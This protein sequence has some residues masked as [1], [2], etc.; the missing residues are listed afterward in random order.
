MV[1]SLIGYRGS[2][3]SS[4]G[5]QLAARL[6]WN[7]VDADVE[8]ERR[9]GESI[10]QI[11]ANRGEPYFRHLEASLLAELLTGDQ[12]VLATGGGAILNPATRD[13]LRLAGPVIWLQASAQLLCERILGDAQTADRRPPL[14]GEQDPRTEIELL[15]AQRTPLYTE[16]ASL[17]VQS[18]QRT[19]TAI[20]DEIVSQLPTAIDRAW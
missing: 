13:A 18:E 14:S 11:F 12:L 5:A 16:T 20:V 15:L 2:G 1:I 17:I 10:A 9:A 8:L 4:V 7:F 19:V 3:K 6:N